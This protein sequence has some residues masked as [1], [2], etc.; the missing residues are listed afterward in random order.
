MAKYLNDFQFG[1]GVLGGAE[2]VLR[3]INRVLS[4]SH[5]DESLSMLTVDFSNAFNPVDR[6]VLLHEVKLRCLYTSLW[7]KF[8]YGK[9]TRLYLGDTHIWSTTRVQQ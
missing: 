3:N 6:S 7:V 4:E 5:T 1:V 9:A 2:A 8:L